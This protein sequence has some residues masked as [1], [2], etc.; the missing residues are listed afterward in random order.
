LQAIEDRTAPIWCLEKKSKG[1]SGAAKKESGRSAHNSSLEV[2][3][4]R[5]KSVRKWARTF[6]SGVDAIMQFI[7]PAT[8]Q[9]LT[10]AQQSWAH[11][12]AVIRL[13]QQ[14]ELMMLDALTGAI[15]NDTAV[16]SSTVGVTLPKHLTDEVCSFLITGT[17]YFDFKGR[18]GLINTLKKFVPDSHYLVT[19]VK[20]DKYKD[21]LERLWALRN[22]ASHSSPQ[23]K[24]SALNAVRLKRMSSVG[25]WLK[26]QQRCKNLAES[27]KNLA[28]EI[29][30]GAPY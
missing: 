5:K 20:K 12:Y 2:L 13:Y 9:H 7:S 23:A 29:E 1:F 18:A 11:E 25:S 4:P 10:D 30:A 19:A 14:F 28:C 24:K 17:G 16:V 21:A 26:R 27:L 15:N 8:L 3:V 22:F 6:Q